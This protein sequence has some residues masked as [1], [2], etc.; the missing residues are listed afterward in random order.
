MLEFCLLGPLLVR[1]DGVAVPLSSGKQRA[2]LATLLLNANRAV[3]TD[4][5]SEVLWGPEP[6]PS[7]RA[8]LHNHV[9]RLRRALGDADHSRIAGLADGYL[10]NVWPGELDSESFETSLS[11]ARAAAG[12]RSWAEAS[13]SLRTALTLWRGQPLTGVPSATLTLQE[14]PRLAE[15]RLQALEARIEAD[16]HLGRHADVIAELQFLTTAHPLREHLHAQLMLALYRCGRQ[17]EALTAYQHARNVLV[18]GRRRT[19]E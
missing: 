18:D 8:S 7:A 6:P 19:R 17:A 5:L 10:I 1:R 3:P 11:A 14:L 2:L 12:R 9:M 13:D 4:Q 15:L 16:L